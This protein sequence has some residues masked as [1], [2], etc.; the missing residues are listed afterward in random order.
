MRLSGW[1]AAAAIAW[2]A[3]ALAQSLEHEVKAAY[4]FR[5]LSFIEWPAQS[6][7]GPDAPLVIGVLG[8]GEVRASLE[9]AVRGRSVQGRP[10]MVRALKEGER[11]AGLHMVFVGRAAASQ[12]ARLAGAP[13]L[14]I[15]GESEGAL[16][17]GAMVN[18]VLVDGR[19][20]FEVA[21]EQAERRGVRISS[22]MLAV[23]QAVR[24]GT[25]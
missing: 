13:A 5:F 1:L 12:I 19:L 4:L 23:A 25:P 8:A 6:F 16:E 18:F 10:V 17:H 11:P 22:R 7:A 9:A 14:L 15:V 20:R 3:L 24:Q 21:P 2:V